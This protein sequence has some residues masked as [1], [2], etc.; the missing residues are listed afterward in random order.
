M[1]SHVLVS[2]FGR[3]FPSGRIRL[4]KPIQDSD[5]DPSHYNLNVSNP[6]ASVHNQQDG[7]AATAIP[8]ADSIQADKGCTVRSSF[9]PRKTRPSRTFVASARRADRPSNQRYGTAQ[10]PAAHLRRQDVKEGEEDVKAT[11]RKRAKKRSAGVFRKEARGTKAGGKKRQHSRRS[12][13]RKKNQANPK[14]SPSPTPRPP[15]K[16]IGPIPCCAIRCI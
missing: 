9:A 10:E 5:P 2:N 13:R 7:C 11:R 15:L 8:L 3:R 14:P 6:G 1:T 16:P 12:K 4:S